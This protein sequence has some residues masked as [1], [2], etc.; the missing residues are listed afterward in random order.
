MTES[1]YDYIYKILL[2]GESGCGKSCLI[3]RYADNQFNDRH[4]STIGVDFKIKNIEH[5]SKPSR[6]LIFR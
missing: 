2:V 1:N 3:I 4:I 6:S 5:Q